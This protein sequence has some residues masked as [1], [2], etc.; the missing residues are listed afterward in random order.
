MTDFRFV[1]LPAYAA[2]ILVICQFLAVVGAAQDAA[3]IDPR[4][5]KALDHY[6][7]T[8]GEAQNYTYTE[9]YQI[10]ATTPRARKR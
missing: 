7:Q 3:P 10:S 4:L 6:H 9:R 2:S 5:Q 1:Q 8:L